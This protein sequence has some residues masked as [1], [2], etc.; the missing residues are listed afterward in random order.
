MNYDKPFRHKKRGVLLLVGDSGKSLFGTI[1]ALI[2]DILDVKIIDMNSESIALSIENYAPSVIT[3]VHDGANNTVFLATLELFKKYAYKS[4]IISTSHFKEIEEI[5]CSAGYSEYWYSPIGREVLKKRI[6]TISAFSEKITA[7]DRSFLLKRSVR[8]R[9][10]IVEDN[11][12]DRILLVETLKNKYELMI[13]SSAKEALSILAISQEEGNEIAGIILD[14]FLP[15][16]NGFDVFDSI[17]ADESYRD[18]PILF[19]TSKTAWRDVLHGLNLGA[20]DYLKK[21]IQPFKV[22]AK[23]NAAMFRA[24]IE[25]VWRIEKGGSGS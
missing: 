24:R 17:R 13:V 19:S 10:L 7:L 18:I 22:L 14:V 3:F 5:V 12:Y 4:I 2:G 16:E 25:Q 20:A 21:P 8:T 11:E 15:G 6:D 9:L 1:S 23:V